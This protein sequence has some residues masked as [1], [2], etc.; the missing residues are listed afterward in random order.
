M[1]GEVSPN[2]G[3]A[4]LCVI[5]VGST[6]FPSEDAPVHHLTTPLFGDHLEQSL[7]EVV[8]DGGEA[9]HLVAE[10]HQPQIVHVVHVVL[11]DVHSVLQSA[12]RSE[13]FSW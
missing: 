10:D 8:P 5:G 1:R 9:H 6:K 4:K 12:E 7:A 13:E 11:L 2:S 3:F